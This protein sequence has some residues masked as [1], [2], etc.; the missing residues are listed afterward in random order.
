MTPQIIITL[1]VLA[2]L[3]IMLLTHKLP[4]GLTGMFCVGLLVLLGVTDLKT[5]M[6]GFSSS[7]TVMV[8]SMIVVASQL[9]KTSIISRIRT[10]MSK[11]QGKND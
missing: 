9:S 10:A 3:V 6:S 7:T 4:Y 11:L 2:F 1:C 8:A 5:A